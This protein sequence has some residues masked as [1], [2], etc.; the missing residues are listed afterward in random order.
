M[1]YDA[2]LSYSHAADG[3]LAPALQRALHRF[4]RP[5]N[6]MRALR[7]FRDTTSLAAT[8][9][10]WPAIVAALGQS[11]HFLLLA[12]PQAAASKWVQREVEWWFANR[13]ADKLFVLLTAGTIAWDENTRDFD[14]K[15]T[16]ALPDLVRGKFQSEPLYVDL[17]WADDQ[18][19]LS[20][21][22]TRF[23][24]AILD[25]AAPLHGKDK[26]QLDGEDVRQFRRTRR[27]RA[28]AVAGLG[29]LALATTSAAVVA[30]KERNLAIAQ[31]RI[32]LSR[33]LAAEALAGDTRLDVAFL[34]AAAANRLSETPQAR[35]ALQRML[36]RT[37]T[38]SG[39]LASDRPEQRLAFSP[40]GRLL[41]SA[42]GNF[43]D[44]DDQVVYLW[45]IDALQLVGELRPTEKH[46]RA[47]A[48]AFH[49]G[50]NTLAVGYLDGVI[51]F[52]DVARREPTGASLKATFGADSLAFS[53]DG[54]HLLSAT[55]SGV[56]LWDT[57]RRQLSPN[58]M[59]Q[60]IGKV[61]EV[62]FGPD[63]TTA[64]AVTSDHGG[65]VIWDIKSGQLVS[66]PRSVGGERV[67]AFA[68]H[69]DGTSWLF[70]TSKGV[71]LYDAKTQVRRELGHAVLQ[72][73]S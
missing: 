2:F 35:A 55:S 33:Q 14:W 47:Q 66:A 42:P 72:V 5:W 41:A 48:I 43:A 59:P 30:V 4:A 51:L 62:A 67:T 57:T 37:P 58:R 25:I 8:P 45:S 32:A 71:T 1:R 54:R 21:Q 46:Q 40:D 18:D 7:V 13:P 73:W 65:V 64:A 34:L 38:V 61:R 56:M 44:W 10:L 63:G 69:P 9:E 17:T 26:D 16:T 53:P 52:W 11:S 29:A 22:N 23:R 19:H 24:Q 70:G 31:A 50:S 68:F 12:S 20:L 36:M 15:L 49:P 28:A 60:F 39:V 27:L 6:R 3:K